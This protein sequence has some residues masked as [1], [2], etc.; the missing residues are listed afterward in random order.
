MYTA[1]ELSI[2]SNAALNDALFLLLILL[3]CGCI[4]LNH[5]YS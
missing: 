2:L 1:V 4:L 3:C 5:F